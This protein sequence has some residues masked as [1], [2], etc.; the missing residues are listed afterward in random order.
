MQDIDTHTTS[1][2]LKCLAANVTSDERQRLVA[3]ITLSMILA[4]R[5]SEITPEAERM[6]NDLLEKNGIHET[7]PGKLLQALADLLSDDDALPN[8]LVR[9]VQNIA[10]DDQQRRQSRRARNASRAIF[11]TK[12][13]KTNEKPPEG[14]IKAMPWARFATA[15][16]EGE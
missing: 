9:G 15:K 7:D 6:T 16:K 10:I 14:S 11:G 3:S 8:A 12:P 2:A 13:V 1:N 4:G 5:Q